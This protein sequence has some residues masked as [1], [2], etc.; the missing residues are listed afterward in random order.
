MGREENN[1]P[2]EPPSTTTGISRRKHRYPVEETRP[3]GD[4]EVGCSGQSC[5][6]CTGGVIADCV[7]VCCCPCAVVNFFTLTFLKLPWMMGRKC[8]GLDNKKKRRKK[9][10][11]DDTDKDR[12]GISR[13]DKGVNR[14]SQNLEEEEKEEYSARFEAEKVWLELYK[15]DH[16]GFGRLSFTG[17]QSL[18]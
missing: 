4:S 3:P 15:I 17:I 6:S 1:C 7:A 18:E 13:K 14:K 10:K 8:L 16:L 5:R 2:C 11:N 12:N 9:L